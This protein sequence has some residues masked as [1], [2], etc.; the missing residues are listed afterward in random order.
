MPSETHVELKTADGR[1]P[2]VAIVDGNRAGAMVTSVLVEA[3]GCWPLPV[4]TAEAGLALIR[5]DGYID[6]VVVDLA[7][8][9]MDGIVVVQLIQA[10]GR[11]LPILGLAGKRSDLAAPRNRAAG[12]NAILLKPYSPGELYNAIVS[13]LRKARTA[14]MFHQ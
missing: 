8:P 1:P 6:L 7:L 2:R 10:L 4:A 3:F 5:R 11:D 12:L 14:V 13:A 9:D